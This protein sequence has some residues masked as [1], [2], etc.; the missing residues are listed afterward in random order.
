MDQ[1]EK[2][3]KQIESAAKSVKG[4]LVNQTNSEK[5]AHEIS[6]QIDKIENELKILN[7][8]TKGKLAQFV[9]SLSWVKSNI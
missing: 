8:M 5:E 4:F 7:R 6:E 3:D 2:D 1:I 9:N